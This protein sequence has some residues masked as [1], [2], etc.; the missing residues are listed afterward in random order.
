[1]ENIGNIIFLDE[2]ALVRGAKQLGF[3][4]HTRTP[5]GII[6]SAVKPEHLFF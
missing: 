4:F 1:M 3:V 5:E 2:G 6:I